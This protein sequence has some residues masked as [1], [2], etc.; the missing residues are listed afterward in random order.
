M[1]ICKSCEKAEVYRD[2]GYPEEAYYHC[3][4][5]NCGCGCHEWAASA[6]KFMAE[7]WKEG[8]RIRKVGEIR[9]SRTRKGKRKT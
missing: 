8:Q 2:L 1:L 5:E 7:N 4:S 3:Y 9:R 6:A